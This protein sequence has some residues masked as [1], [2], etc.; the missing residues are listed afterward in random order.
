[1]VQ[2]NGFSAH[3]DRDELLKWLASLRKPPRRLFVTHGESSIAQHFASL[4]R[5]KTSW[6]IAV[7][8]YQEE[9]L[10]D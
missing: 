3:A 2:I 4:V 6:E 10:L 9:F 5:D 8:E 7:P 1:V